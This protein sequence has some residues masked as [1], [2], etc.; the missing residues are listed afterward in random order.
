MGTTTIMVG[1]TTTATDG[2]TTA[3]VREDSKSQNIAVKYVMGNVDLLGNYLRR[4]SGLTEL[5]QVDAAATTGAYAPTAKLLGLGA[6]YNFS[7][8]TMLYVRY[9]SIKGINANATTQT[10]L[11]NGVAGIGSFGNA[12]QTTSAVGL[13][14]VF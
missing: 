13:R 12:S 3:K 7:K 8:N 10:A 5:Q 2:V 9:E 4:T 14:M 6:N 11:T 1:M